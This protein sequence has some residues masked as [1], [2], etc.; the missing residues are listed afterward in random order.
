MT[1]SPIRP[2]PRRVVRAA[3]VAVLG[4]LLAG[5]GSG[6][7]DPSAAQTKGEVTVTNCGAEETFPSPAERLLVTGDG[8]MV[9]MVLALGAQDQIAGVT[10]VDGPNETLSVAYGQDVVDALPVASKD[11]PT[12]ENT[13]ATKPDVVVSGWNYGFSEE[14]NFTPD[15]LRDHGI[16]PYVLSESCRQADGARGTM[17]PWEALYADLEN[18]GQITGRDDVAE[19]V[20][21]DIKDR[22]DALDG[23]PRATKTPTVFLFDSGTKDIFTSGAFGG[24]QAIIEAAGAKNAAAD[25]QDTWTEVSWERLVA[26]EPDFFAF[27]DYSGQSFQDKVRVLE[28][29]PATK[30]LPAVREKR[31]LNLPISAWTSSPLN[32]DAAEHLRMALEDHGLA[33]GTDIEPTHDL[34][35]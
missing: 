33:P 11:Y 35:P 5:C 1:S 27:V 12:M 28:S 4:G 23:L 19:E 6:A 32:I 31:Y 20:T 18:L 24:P 34:R 10:G 14:K 16:A 9:A 21:T 3:A 8:N 17:P 29:N 13:I 26:S 2:A 7:G 22:L 25:V 15:A 30:D